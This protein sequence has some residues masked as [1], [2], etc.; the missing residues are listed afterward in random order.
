MDTDQQKNG[1]V[2]DPTPLAGQQLGH[3]G[4]HD[5]AVIPIVNDWVTFTRQ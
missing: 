1:F 3:H 4:H 2:L 5:S